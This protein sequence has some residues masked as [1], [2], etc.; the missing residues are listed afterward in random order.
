MGLWQGKLLSDRMWVQ[1]EEPG[2]WALVTI[3]IDG[4]CIRQGQEEREA[5]HGASH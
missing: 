3:R 5:G 4:R 2:W 1:R